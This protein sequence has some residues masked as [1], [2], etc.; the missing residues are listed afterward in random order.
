MTHAARRDEVAAA[1]DIRAAKWL[2]KKK[3][4]RARAGELDRSTQ[5]GRV[6]QQTN[7]SATLRV[8]TMPPAPERRPVRRHVH[9]RLLALRDGPRAASRP[10]HP[11]HRAVPRQARRVM[12]PFDPSYSHPDRCVVC[13]KP[14]AHANHGA[15][16]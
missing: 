12:H 5:G 3:A 11:P 15:G 9:L 1:R 10:R 7:T 8:V 13:H 16:T 6:N 2:V 14:K 4:E